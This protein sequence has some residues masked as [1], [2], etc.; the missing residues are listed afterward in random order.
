MLSSEHRRSLAGRARAETKLRLSR[1]LG[2]DLRWT[3]KLYFYEGWPI[4]RAK[5]PIVM[6]RDCRMRGGPV[7]T[8]LTTSPSGRIELGVNVG[9]GFGGEIYSDRLITID[10]HSSIGPYVTIY[11]TSFHSVD[12][13]SEV[14]RK[15]VEIGK[16][17]WIGRQVI[18]LPGV[19]IGDHA[20]VGSGSVLSR[21]VPPRTLVA[22][23]PPK[24]IREVTASDGWQRM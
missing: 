13:G 18:I 3:G 15:P 17:V 22:G 24:V 2:N 1:M 10:D 12:E 20:V 16:N 4:F 5:G 21:D 23:N 8:R 9:I 19:R 7:R 6:G 14:K 11:D